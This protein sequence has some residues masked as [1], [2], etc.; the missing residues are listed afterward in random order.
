MIDAEL[1]NLAHPLVRAAIA[2]ARAWPG[3]SVELLLPRDATPDLAAM[4]G[5]EGVLAVTLVDYAGFEPVQRLIAGGIVA[6]EPLDPSVAAGI[7]QLQA[8]DSQTNWRHGRPAGVRRRGRYGGFHRP[9]RGR[10]A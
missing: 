10:E 8:I 7:L 9:T 6:G 5:K 2:D 4:A 3:G 1:L